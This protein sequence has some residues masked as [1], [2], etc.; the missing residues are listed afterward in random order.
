MNPDS[1]ASPQ[2]G[3]G[4]NPLL[5]HLNDVDESHATT[6][7]D[8]A[9]PGEMVQPQ[10][11][12]MS[13]A[14]TELKTPI[15]PPVPLPVEAPV[16]QPAPPPPAPVAVPPA[17]ASPHNGRPT[18]VI[19]VIIIVLAA[20]GGGA[21]WYFKYYRNKPQTTTNNAQQSVQV[22]P[23]TPTT[24]AQEDAGGKPL[25]A[26]G[27]SGKGQVTLT[28]SMP[29]SASSG[30]VTPQ[31]E[32][33]PLATAFTNQPTQSG[34]ATTATGSTINSSLVVT[35][36]GAGSYHWQARFTSGSTDGDW[37]PFAAGGTTTADF[38]IDLTPPAA[39]KVSS[40]GGTSVKSSATSSTTT[41]N[42]PVIAGTADPGSA[43][44]INIQ[45]DNL[46]LSGT[47]DASGK[48]SITP[49]STI[50]N[51]DHTLA[52]VAADAA[53]NTTSSSFTLSINTV[54]A[55]PAT[56]QVAPTGDN[57]R[58]L[59]LIGLI[60]VVGAAVGLTLVRR[61]DRAQV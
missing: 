17:P 55:A 45:P 38:M 51:G 33:E 2:T 41:N 59:T 34:V 57:T 35:G 39:A 26:A 15:P 9:H 54:A 36:L 21:W 22:T 32:V 8:F 28:F 6:R 11:T 56:A 25:T 50:P 49:T 19:I 1:Q 7:V 42:Q 43:I 13:V 29:T 18:L 27:T 3:S 5:A 30:S 58:P 47:A 4:V 53:G 44:A 20:L 16:A 52:I 23:Q 37:A 31:V 10:P 12:V 48:W 14:P 40:I 61:R 60:L 24:L 46:A